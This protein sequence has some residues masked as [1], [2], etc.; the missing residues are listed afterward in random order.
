LLLPFV[1]LIT[2]MFGARAELF[3]AQMLRMSRHHQHLAAGPRL[4][5]RAAAR[6]CAAW[7]SVRSAMTRCK[8]SAVSSSTLPASAPL[9]TIALCPSCAFRSP[10]GLTA[11]ARKDDDRRLAQLGI[12]LNLAR[13]SNPTYPAK[14]RS[15]PTAK[16]EGFLSHSESRSAAARARSL[17]STSFAPT[18]RSTRKAARPDHPHYQPTGCARL[19][20]ILQPIDRLLEAVRGKGLIDKATPLA[21]VRIAARLRSSLSERDVAGFRGLRLKLVEHCPPPSLSSL[22]AREEPHRVEHGLLVMFAGHRQAIVAGPGENDL[23]AT[24]TSQVDPDRVLMGIVLHPTDHVVGSGITSPRRG[25]HPDFP[26]SNP[27]GKTT[28]W[29]GIASGRVQATISALA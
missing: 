5:P 12:P 9:H 21:P 22:L 13:R 7:P 8:K 4:S 19:G 18:T 20:E 10:P 25:V 1:R 26:L 24:V 6:S 11:H 23:K 14:R 17:N 29:Y 16:I 28:G 2:C 27:R 3:S 15:S